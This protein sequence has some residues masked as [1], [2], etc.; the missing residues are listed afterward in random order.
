MKSTT[1]VSGGERLSD[2]RA[3]GVVGTQKENVVAPHGDDTFL[4]DRGAGRQRVP[5]QQLS[6]RKLLSDCTSNALGR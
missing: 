1:F 3:C 6:S 5:P 4:V 2:H